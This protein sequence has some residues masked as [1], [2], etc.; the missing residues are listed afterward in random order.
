MRDSVEE[1]VGE[2]TINPDPQLIDVA[3]DKGLYNLMY[4]TAKNNNSSFMME[5]ISAQIDLSTSN[6]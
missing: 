6:H 2:F 5:Y 3:L 1:V 4:K